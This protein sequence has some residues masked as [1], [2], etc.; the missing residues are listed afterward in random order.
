MKKYEAVSASTLIPRSYTIIRVDGKAF[1][2]FTKGFNKPFD[3]Y[4]V[5]RMIETANYLAENIQNCRLV[6]WQ[7][8]EISLVLTDFTEFDT[9]QWFAG[10]V[11]KIVSI[12]AGMASAYFTNLTGSVAVFDSRV[13]QVPTLTEVY[14]YFL[15]RQRDAIRNSILG[16]AQSIYSH[17][18]MHGKNTSQ[19]QDM[20][21]DRG[22][23]FQERIELCG[24]KLEKTINPNWNDLPDHLKRGCFLIPTDEGW[25]QRPNE[26]S[27]EF[28][29]KYVPLNE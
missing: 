29:R 4:I 16:S 9:Q 7:S 6:Y 5:N 20:I 28:I 27:E 26:I 2:S 18:E 12:S 1:H 19:L 22:K 11:Q 25:K 21:F 3:R 8:D 14:N 17:K 13:F 10:K 23:Q 15:W 24:F